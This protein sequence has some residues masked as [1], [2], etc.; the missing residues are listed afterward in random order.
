VRAGGG[1]QRP[2]RNA[3]E[4]DMM[5]TVSGDAQLGDLAPDRGRPRSL[6]AFTLLELLIVIAIIGLLAGI[7][8]PSLAQARTLAVRATC[9]A[10]LHHVHAVLAMYQ[11]DHEDAYPCATDPVAG[12]V[13]LWMGR[14]WRPFVEPYL[15]R[16]LDA[17]NPSILFCQ[18]DPNGQTYDGTSYAYSMT[19]YHSPAQINAMNSRADTYSN[20]QPFVMQRSEDV[21]AANAK[22]LIGEW[23][24]NHP[25]IAEDGGWWCWRGQRNYV[26]ANGR[27]VN[28][29]ATEIRPA[30]DDLPDANL[31]RDGIHGHDIR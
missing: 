2:A 14:G 11:A 23:T 24:S 21:A 13:W 26:L 15:G 28:L 25:Q 16:G 27:V 8:L 9:Q 29:R 3:G 31:T 1:G 7:L 5:R 19:F 6:R 20:P 30:R 4:W 10:N 12:G 17:E 18:G 22:I